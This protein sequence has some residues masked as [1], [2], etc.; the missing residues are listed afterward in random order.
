MIAILKRE[1]SRTL[2]KYSTV[3]G[4]RIGD[5]GIRSPLNEG[6]NNTG[7]WHKARKEESHPN[8]IG[9]YIASA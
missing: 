9:T 4:I 3:L 5:S 1:D 2:V 8:C 6:M 7:S